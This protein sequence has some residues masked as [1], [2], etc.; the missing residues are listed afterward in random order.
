MAVSYKDYYKLLG[1]ERAASAEEVS[2]AYKKLAR[3]YHPDLNPA[4]KAQERFKAASAAYDLL[5][6]PEQRRRF[7]QGTH[8]RQIMRPQP[9]PHP[10]ALAQVG[11]I[12]AG[13]KGGMGG[14]IK[15]KVQHKHIARGQPEHR[16]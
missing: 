8:A 12:S 7:G 10:G 1:V 4:P 6:D 16:R 9:R 13:G 14:R 2:K 5:K 3:K 11:Q 15:H